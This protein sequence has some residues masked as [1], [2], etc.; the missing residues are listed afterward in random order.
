VFEVVSSLNFVEP[1]ELMETIGK[2][3]LRGYDWRMRLT[4][5][6]T[7][8]L[9][10][11][12]IKSLSVSDISD[13]ICPTRRDLYFKKGKNRAQGIRHTR[14]W[15]GIAGPLVEDYFLKLFD[16][17]V[18]KRSK[19]SYETIKKAARVRNVEFKRNVSRQ[20]ERLNSLKSRASENPEWL[21]GLLHHAGKV[22][23]GLRSLDRILMKRSNLDAIKETDVKRNEINPKVL[24]IGISRRASPDFLLPSRKIVGDIKSGF[25]FKDHFLYTCTG[26]ALAYEN[27][28]GE[29]ND[30]N[31]GVIFFFPT[32][33]SD[34]AKPIS[35]GQTYLFVIDDELRDQFKR[36]RDEAYNIISKESPPAMP[37]DRG[38]CSYCQFR[39]ACFGGA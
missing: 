7:L 37:S 39:E 23:L 16:H 38:S 1:R 8:P 28:M 31:I 6:F 2:I 17:E 29:G 36:R 32:R 34:F 20:I 4:G 10:E 35:F 14:T 27:A 11:K 26:Y 30:I 19:L 9:S 3:E 13:Y 24:E 18:N 33:S 15:G 25:G 5:Q 12:R 21:L 22:S